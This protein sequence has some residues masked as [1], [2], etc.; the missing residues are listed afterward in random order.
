MKLSVIIP[1]YNAEP[2]IKKLLEALSFQTQKLDEIIV[3]DSSSSDNT[4][5][6]A[7]NFG[8]KVVIIP[9]EEFDHGGTRT[10]AAKLAAGDILIYLTQDAIPADRFS[11]EN[12]VKV[13]ES[14]EVGAAYGRQVP[15]ENTNLFGKHLRYFNYPSVSFTKSLEDRKNL[16][17][18]VVF[19]SNSFAAYRKSVLEEIG[20]FKSGVIFGE[21]SIAAAKILL[22]GY[23]IAYSA[24]ARVFHSH[25]YSVLQDFKRYFD[26]GA[27]HKME[28]WILDTFGKP[29]GEG[30]RYIKSEFRFL[31]NNNAYYLIPEFLIRNFLKYLGYKLGFHC[32]K[33]PQRLRKKLS[34]FPLWWDKE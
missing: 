7:K 22:A 4:V 14:E 6:I 29:E 33:I 12:I 30:L 15:Y 32:T 11:I 20:W 34:M 26:V 9:K 21:D 27:F 5:E 13:F 23:K 16:G 2:Y 17:F 10:K 8:A 24:E 28:K 1:T 31:I 3:I 25:S 19:L 18:K